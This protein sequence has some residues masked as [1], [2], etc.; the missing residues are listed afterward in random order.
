MIKNVLQ[1]CYTN[2]SRQVGNIVSSGWQAVCVS[3]D[4]PSDAFSACTKIQNANSSIQ[5]TMTDENGNVLNLFEICGDGTFLYVI[6]TQYGLLDRLGRANMF[7]HAYIFPCKDSSLI[8]DPNSFLTLSNDNFK[9]N[10][11]A[12]MEYSDELSR[13]PAFGIDEAMKRCKLDK[14]RLLTLVKSVYA[15]MSDKKTGKPL[16]IQY[17]G[18]EESLRGLLFCIYYAMPLSLRKRLCVASVKTDNTVG[19]N[20]IFSKGALEQELHFNPVSGESSILTARIERRFSRLGFL[21][22]TVDNITHPDIQRYFKMLEDRTIELG[23]TTGTNELIMKIAHFQLTNKKLCTVEDSEL[24]VRL[25]D[26]L[27]SNSVGNMAMN[28]YIAKLLLE[29]TSRKLILTDENESALVERLGISSP[30]ALM[31]AAEKY[32]FYRFNELAPS[33]AAGKLTKMSETVFFNYRKKLLS[34]DTGRKILDYYYAEIMLSKLGSSWDGIRQIVDTTMDMPVKTLTDDKIDECASRLYYK[35]LDDIKEGHI[36]NIVSEY[37][38][39]ITILQQTFGVQK[40]LERGAAAREAFW[41]H[42]SYNNINFSML[43]SYQEMEINSQK[44]QRLLAYC[45][46]PALLVSMGEKAFYRMSN[47]FFT[48]AYDEL[49]IQDKSVAEKLI[50]EAKAVSVHQNKLFERWCGIMFFTDDILV[51]DDLL[52]L[53]SCTETS[54]INMILR[55]F[56][57]FVI[58]YSDALLS[59]LIKKEIA[60]IVKSICVELDSEKEPVPLDGWLLL[61]GCL[62]TNSFYIFDEN[63][64]FILNED[65]IKVVSDSSLIRKDRYRNDADNYVRDRRREYKTVKKWLSALQK[66]KKNAVDSRK[67]VHESS[68]GII[69]RG[70]STL[71]RYTQDEQWRETSNNRIERQDDTERTHSN[72]TKYLTG[73]KHSTNRDAQSAKTGFFS[74]LLGKK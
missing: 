11:E 50:A 65:D 33:E 69:T 74:G 57:R 59:P 52:D 14:G 26:A 47:K 3:P 64:L 40:S 13:L 30:G 29:I 7:S 16:Y 2:A 32:N 35:S 9:D 70:L 45:S 27:R 66:L 61:G 28:N 60:E 42:I 18:S 62:Y 15:Q 34:L 36:K 20:V 73:L 56:N 31:D 1:C 44:C 55:S 24:E 12:A 19:K 67:G 6:R 51:F 23:D 71:S 53:Y 48:I 5:N 10:E 8:S 43:H 63:S 68:Q 22:F 54:D 41:E 72:D 37:K 49:G 17:D 58:S 39:Y 25:S 21:D 46:L 38:K 4:L